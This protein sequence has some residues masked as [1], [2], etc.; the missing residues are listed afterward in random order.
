MFVDFALQLAQVRICR[1]QASHFRCASGQEQ[2]V[3]RFWQVFLRTC[4][5][6]SPVLSQ[7]ENPWVPIVYALF[8]GHLYAGWLVVLV[9]RFDEGSILTRTVNC[10]KGAQRCRCVVKFEH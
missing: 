8:A 4:P 10:R 3:I 1:R 5:T 6:E 9:F 7:A 2:I